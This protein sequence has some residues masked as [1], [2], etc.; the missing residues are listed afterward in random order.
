MSSHIQILHRPLPV[1]LQEIINHMQ[2]G[3]VAITPGGENIHYHELARADTFSA[4]DVLRI[5]V[6]GYIF[7][8]R[9]MVMHGGS[10]VSSYRRDAADSDAPS[11]VQLATLYL[12]KL[13]DPTT[14]PEAPIS[15]PNDIRDSLGA[16]Q[17]IAAYRSFH[18]DQSYRAFDR[19]TKDL[20]GSLLSFFTM[21]Q[22]PALSEF[23]TWEHGEVDPYMLQQQ[24]M[25]MHQPPMWHTNSMPY[26]APPA[27]YGP[28]GTS[29]YKR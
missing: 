22:P 4:M 15:L 13:K 6:S 3:L 21:H 19:F 23:S 25:H 5:D 7:G 12:T 28:Y 1:V 20:A 2:K 29:G 26:G 24:H 10:Y 11:G 27:S 8:A 9:V 14:D 18:K 17:Q 16:K